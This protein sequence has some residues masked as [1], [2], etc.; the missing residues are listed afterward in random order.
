MPLEIIVLRD[1]GIPLFH[2]GAAGSKRLDELVAAFLSL[3]GHVIEKFSEEG[4]R[5]I[6]FQ[7]S[8]FVWNKKGD[9]YFIAFVSAHDNSQVYDVILNQLAERFVSRY[10]GELL[11]KNDDS[12][13]YEAFAETIESI[14]HRFDG[15]PGMARRYKTCLLPLAEMT[16]IRRSLQNIEE[17]EGVDR[18]GY[19]TQD[20][21]V[22]AS[23]LRTYELE[24]G[25][26]LI[27]SNGI[28]LSKGAQEEIIKHPSLDRSNSLLFHRTPNGMILVLIVD[29]KKN[30]NQ[31]YEDLKEED[32]SISDIDLKAGTRIKPETEREPLEFEEQKILIPLIPL[33]D[34]EQLEQPLIAEIPR[35]IRESVLDV[36]RL[37]DNDYTI[38]EIRDK[39]GLDRKKLDEILAQMVGRGLARLSEA[40][41]TLT[42]DDSR[43]KA[44]LDVVGM[45]KR[46]Q[47]VLDTIWHQ[48]DGEHSI[49]EIADNTQEPPSRIV[50]VLRTLGNVV[51]WK[52]RRDA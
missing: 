12:S 37:A 49:S 51:E 45:P 26:D 29:S 34:I 24:A 44:Y 38:A 27:S 8:K 23:N 31:F 47:K 43:F 35:S 19:L 4:I 15:V 25:L 2:Y 52:T 17:I 32:K 36:L 30:L 20:G 21:F 18:A 42:L 40:Y 14:L 16:M 10:Y 28:S 39:S 9:L 48:L 41:P 13:S 6:T 11:E 5:E 7:E 33:D 22:I 46:K 50:S 3:V 1:S